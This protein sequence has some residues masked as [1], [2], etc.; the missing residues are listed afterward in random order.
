MSPGYLAGAGKALL[1]KF[2]EI[3]I[4]ISIA[5]AFEEIVP[6]QNPD[7]VH[8]LRRARLARSRNEKTANCGGLS[9]I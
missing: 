4:F 1:C 3:P 8:I 7:R 2:G 9:D 6:T 5:L